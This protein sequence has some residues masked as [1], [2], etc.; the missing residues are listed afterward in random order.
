ML[1]CNWCG[2]EY[3]KTGA[4]QKFCTRCKDDRR[5]NYMRK[6]WKENFPATGVGKGGNQQP[7]KS[8]AWL[9]GYTSYGKIKLASLREPYRCER[10]GTDL[11]CWIKAGDKNGKWCV[12]HIDWDHYNSELGNLELLCKSCHQIEHEVH[13]NF[14]SKG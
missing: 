14:N 6:Y 13:K 5:K 9:G 11:T 1:V 12:H 10:C 3:T 7:Q 4:N 8:P 2:R